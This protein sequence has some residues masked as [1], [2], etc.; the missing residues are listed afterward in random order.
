MSNGITRV[1]PICKS[2]WYK[3]I[4]KK[5]SF[6][7]IKCK[8]CFTLYAKKTEDSIGYFDYSDYYGEENL[9]IPD[10]VYETYRSIIKDFESHRVNS[11]FL[12]VGCGAGTL[13]DIAVERNWNAVGIEVSKPAAEHLKQRGLNVFEGTLEEAKF[14]DNHFDVVTCTEVIEHVTNPKELLKEIA[15][16]LAPT[17]I[18]WMTTPHGRGLSG[19]FLGSNWTVVAPPEHLNLFSIKSLKMCLE[20]AG[21]QKCRIV[22]GGLNPFELYQFLRGNNLKNSLPEKETCKK[23]KKTSQGFERVKKSYQLN[24]WFVSGRNK[25]KVKN[26]INLMLDKTNLGDTIKVWATFE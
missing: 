1:C 2:N 26:L 25:Q 4:G 8:D 15:R 20:E 22:S 17:G 11:R 18:L 7:I 9:N 5:N 24:K 3:T 10:F 23:P 21:F 14:P 16:V 12:D 6:E 13:L 19:K